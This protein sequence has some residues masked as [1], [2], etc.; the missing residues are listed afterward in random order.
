MKNHFAITLNPS[1]FNK[2]NKLDVNAIYTKGCICSSNYKSLPHFVQR[3][4]L[5]DI[6]NL[7]KSKVSGDYSEPNYEITKCGNYHIH[8]HFHTDLEE[9]DFKHIVDGINKIFSNNDKWKALY[10]EQTHT[11]KEPWHKYEIKEHYLDVLMGLP[12]PEHSYD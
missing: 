6:Y 5:E 8:A 7:F 9:S 10:I 11:S 2:W 3:N 1:P 4:L 12:L